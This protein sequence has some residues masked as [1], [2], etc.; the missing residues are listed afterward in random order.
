MTATA[1]TIS[2]MPERVESIEGT[3]QPRP[4][5]GAGGARG[6]GGLCEAG[7]MD[8]ERRDATGSRRGADELTDLGRRQA[9]DH[10]RARCGPETSRAQHRDNRQF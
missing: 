5:H 9:L 8:R 4:R 3:Q 2:A 1:P 10:A 6:L 7:R